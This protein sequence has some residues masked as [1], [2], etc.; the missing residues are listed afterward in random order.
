MWRPTAILSTSLILPRIWK[1]I[2]LE[3]NH[4]R[5]GGSSGIRQ[6]PGT[7]EG[8]DERQSANFA[9]APRLRPDSRR[10]PLPQLRTTMRPASGRRCEGTP[11]ALGNAAEMRYASVRYGYAAYLRCASLRIRKQQEG[12]GLLARRS[13]PRTPSS[14]GSLAGSWIAAWP[15]LPRRVLP[16]RSRSDTSPSTVLASVQSRMQCQPHRSRGMP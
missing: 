4:G 11:V 14:L 3:L 5:S 8:V 16:D 1:S 9:T 10:R 13:R 12:L 7:G 6:P 2:E 15:D